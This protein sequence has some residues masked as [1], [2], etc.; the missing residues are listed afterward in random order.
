MAVTLN[1]CASSGGVPMPLAFRS[2][3]LVVACWP[4][5]RRLREPRR[6]RRSSEPI[7]IISEDQGF[8]VL[9]HLGQSGEPSLLVL[10]H[11]FAGAPDAGGSWLRFRCPR[12]VTGSMVKSGGVRRLIEWCLGANQELVEVNWRGAPSRS[13]ACPGTGEPPLRLIPVFCRLATRTS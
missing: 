13:R 5:R 7:L 9:Y 4:G 6:F 11:N 3:V 10:G 1:G 2:M 8:I 12:W